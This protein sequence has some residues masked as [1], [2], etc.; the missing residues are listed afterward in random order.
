MNDVLTQSAYDELSAA[1][2]KRILKIEQAKVYSGFAK[3]PSTCDAILSNFPDDIF[4]RYTAKQIGEIMQI[5]N[6]AYHTGV[7]DSQK[8]EKAV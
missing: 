4:D 5:A 1:D 6:K 8:R 2:R 7:E 3:Y